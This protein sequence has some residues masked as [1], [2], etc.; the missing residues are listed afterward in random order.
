MFRKNMAQSI[1]NPRIRDTFCVRLLDVISRYPA[2][3]P[4]TPPYIPLLTKRPSKYYGIM[5]STD[6]VTV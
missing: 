2:L 5:A 1:L 6:L 3:Y 4:L